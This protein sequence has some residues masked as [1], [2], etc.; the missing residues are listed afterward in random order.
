[1]GTLLPTLQYRL[2]AVLRV[3]SLAERSDELRAISE[4]ILAEAAAHK[5]RTKRVLTAEAV[6]WIGARGWPG[7]VR[8]L[9]NVVVAAS[10]SAQGPNIAPADLETW[11]DASGSAPADDDRARVVAAL[12]EYGGNQSRAAK[13]LGISRGTLIS[14][15]RRYGLVRPKKTP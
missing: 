15:I 5:G 2:G 13:L 9:Q 3:P 11:T 4:H 7:N 1:L 14:R 10:A 6:D 8:E 12:A